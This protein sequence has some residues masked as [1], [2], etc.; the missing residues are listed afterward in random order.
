MKTN[1]KSKKLCLTGL[2]FILVSLSVGCQ[3]TLFQYFNASKVEKKD[4]KESKN[5]FHTKTPCYKNSNLSCDVVITETAKNYHIDI[6]PNG[7]S[8]QTIKAHKNPRSSKSKFYQYND[9]NGQ[10]YN[11]VIYKDKTQKPTRVLL[12]IVNRKDQA[13][14]YDLH[15]NTNNKLVTGSQT[16]KC[17]IK[18]N[19]TPC[20]IFI[21]EKNG[22]LVVLLTHRTKL[23][24]NTFDLKD[25]TKHLKNDNT[26]E[27]ISWSK[28]KSKEDYIKLKLSKNN[29][30]LDGS[31]ELR[32][33]S[34]KKSKVHFY[35]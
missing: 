2:L 14:I 28:D 29:T 6:T 7:Q 15:L 33:P 3:T 22:G 12:S 21:S 16:G 18:T 17:Q 8:T 13:K 34:G 27:W 19:Q 23:L 20:K 25:V 32:D 26:Q 35:R 5:T 30:I 1:F 9:D 4:L 11:G 10:L 31:L 24:K